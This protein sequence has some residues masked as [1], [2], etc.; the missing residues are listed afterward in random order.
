MIRIVLIALCFLLQVQAVFAGQEHFLKSA[1]WQKAVQTPEDRERLVFFRT[2]YEKGQD[3]RLPL[4][5][6]P[7]VLHVI[8][9][10]PSDFPAASVLNLRTWAEKHPGWRMKL[11]ADR[12]C[13]LPIVGLQV[14][15]ADHFPLK[16][17]SDIYYQAESYDERSVILRYAILQGEGGVYIDHDAQCLASLEPLRAAHDFFCGLEVPG[18]SVRSSSI[19]PSCHLIGASAHHPILASAQQWLT[20][21]WQAYEEL[22]PGADPISVENRMVHRSVNALSVAIEKASS[23]DGRKDS[24]FPPDYFSSSQREL[25]RYAVVKP[26]ALFG[27]RR[28]QAQ[29]KEKIEENFT[30][31]RTQL[32]ICLYLIFALAA[33]N[34]C[35]GAVIIY[36]YRKG[37]K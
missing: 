2:L 3:Q 8:W 13:S 1:E 37:K 5:E 28:Q 12:D 33:L 25:A 34:L 36:L 6:I 9:L 29:A 35:L 20:A 16:E 10:G 26:Q 32:R 21:H 4:D 30:A 27:Q 17:C 19:N 7:Q 18:P 11:W 15:T 23:R 14:I 22:L 24:V 31:I